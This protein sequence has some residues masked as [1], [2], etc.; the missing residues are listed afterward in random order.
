MGT[1]NY[2]GYS[3]GSGTNPTNYTTDIGTGIPWGVN[4]KVGILSRQIDTSKSGITNTSSDVYEAI[5]CKAGTKILDAWFFVDTAES[6][7]TTA[8][9]SLG[10]TGGTTDGF[11]TAATC[12]A[13]GLHATNGST[14]TAA[15]GVTLTSANTIDL[16]VGTAAFTDCI[17][18]V[19]ALVV[20]MNP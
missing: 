12:A 20:D 3:Q 14:Y 18:T 13:T 1:V 19:Y 17:V 4:S 6:T 8:T 15:G 11:V 2:T 5:Y 9:F 16:L 7:N 10:I